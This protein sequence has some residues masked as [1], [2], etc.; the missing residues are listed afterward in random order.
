MD[1][2]RDTNPVMLGVLTNQSE[3]LVYVGD[4]HRQIYEWRGT[5]TGR[6]TVDHRQSCSKQSTGLR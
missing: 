4:R 6:E 3:Q 2:A 5:C 1:E